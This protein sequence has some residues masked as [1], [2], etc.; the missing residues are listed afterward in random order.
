MRIVD[1][2]DI[3][4]KLIKQE[5]PINKKEPLI[6]IITPFYNSKE[7]F[8]LTK[9]SVLSQTFPYYE[10]IIVDDG[11]TDKDSL[12]ILDTVNKIDSRIKVYKK[13]N[14][15]PS[16]ARD[17]AVNKSSSSVKYLFFLDSDDLIE[18]TTLEIL[19]WSLECNKEAD[20][21]C[22]AIINFGDEEYVGESFLNARLE[23]ENNIIYIS[24]MVR[25]SAFLE[26]GGFGIKEK[27]MYEDWGLWLKLMA[28]NK[29]PMK[30]S[31][32]LFWYR[33]TSKGEFSRAQNNNDKAMNYI[34]SLTPKVNDDLKVI[35]FPEIGDVAPL[36]DTNIDFL[37]PY[38]KNT[39]KIPI[40][41]IIPWMQ[42]GGADIFN[43]NLIKL[44]N[45]NKYETIIITTR[46]SENEIRNEFTKY[47]DKIYELA[48]FLE[49]KDYLKF[50][51][52][53]VESRN[54]KIVF[55]SNSAEGYSFF[56]AIKNK[57]PSIKIIDYVH[58][59]ELN[60]GKGGFARYTELFDNY[61]DKTYTC[62]NFTK[63][64]LETYFKKSNVKTLYIGTDPEKYNIN[65]CDISFLKNKYGI[66]SDYK[67]ISF[68]GRLSDEKR[69]LFFIKLAKKMLKSNKKLL[70]L[71]AGD[72]PLYKE[73][74]RYIRVNNLNKNVI[75]LGWANSKEVYAVSDIVIIC[76]SLEGLALTSFE[77]LS[78]GKPVVSANVGGQAEL[79]N[80]NVGKIIKESYSN[81][82]EEIKLYEN[83]INE[84]L[85]NYSL[86]SKNCRKIILNKFNINSLVSNFESEVDLLLKDG[87]EKIKDSYE[88][89]CEL[90]LIQEYNLHSWLTREYYKKQFKYD[91]ITGENEFIYKD[92]NKESIKKSI[93]KYGILPEVK[94][95]L[96][97]LRNFKKFIY[98]LLFGLAK[99]VKN[100]LFYFIYF[101]KFFIKS[102]FSVFI[103]IFKLI[104]YFIKK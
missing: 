40:L 17:F 5:E 70:F 55:D 96:D 56:P 53:L 19:Y 76:S 103:I 54:I 94:N 81:E 24:S 90:V 2:K 101:I 32:P 38:Y 49:R 45:K 80:D 10:W 42:L 68:V 87:N 23:K 50:V 22:P 16:V 89:I 69:P 91:L 61:I 9:N 88:K 51:L 21:V 35:Q 72:G 67:V 52:Y 13:T 92:E 15:G 46:V 58:A 66:T 63:S 73:L 27:N 77:A 74:K 37:V 47:C 6:A 83:S 41:F 4:S 26:V 7:E 44:L 98:N 97:C 82:K 48:S 36:V 20:F 8:L 25:K 95:I 57:F 62:N 84:V 1:F 39:K 64:Q 34:N 14:G 102:I 43:L 3:P 78:M 65:D 31:T 71:L 59:I 30:I 93:S 79:I 33:K 85:S 100:V 99:Y 28:A 75:L 12:K 29:I 18:P 104:L 11:S 86:L 60:D